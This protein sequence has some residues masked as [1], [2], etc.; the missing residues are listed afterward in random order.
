MK[1]Y[2]FYLSYPIT[3]GSLIDNCNRAEEMVLAFEN[4]AKVNG[5]AFE[6]YAPHRHTCEKTGE[7]VTY[8]KITTDIWKIKA[9]YIA[10]AEPAILKEQVEVMQRCDGVIFA[11]NHFISK[12]CT[13]EMT[14]CNSKKIPYVVHVYFE[15]ENTLAR[16]LGTIAMQEAK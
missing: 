14:I 13:T 1:Q 15:T 6:F 5:Y 8:N 10:K 9:E 2:K 16:M 11:P 4:Y 3:S 7:S 12:G